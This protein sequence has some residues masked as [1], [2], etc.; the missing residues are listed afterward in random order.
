MIISKTRHTSNSS[1]S[2]FPSVEVD[3]GKSL[4]SIGKARG[5]R[6]NITYHA[7][8]IKRIFCFKCSYASITDKLTNLR[9]A[10]IFIF[11]QVD[12]LNGSKWS[13]QFLQVGLSSIFRQVGN[14]DGGRLIYRKH[15]QKFKFKF[16]KFKSTFQIIH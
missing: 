8:K 9:L 14:T 12:S 1:C 7:K 4:Q 11:C 2:I 3:K 6:I 10:S 16:T 15:Q 5:M 13:E